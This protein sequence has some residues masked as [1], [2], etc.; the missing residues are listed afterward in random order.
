MSVRLPIVAVPFYVGHRRS[1]YNYHLIDGHYKHGESILLSAR[2]QRVIGLH[3]KAHRSESSFRLEVQFADWEESRLLAEEILDLMNRKSPP[4]SLPVWTV[5]A[6][7]F[8][9]P[10]W[11]RRFLQTRGVP[12]VHF[13][14]WF[15]RTFEL[16]G[17]RSHFA[18]LRLLGTR[19]V[20]DSCGEFLRNVALALADRFPRRGVTVAGQPLRQEAPLE[21]KRLLKTGEFKFPTHVRS[22]SCALPRIPAKHVTF[23]HNFR[24]KIDYT[25]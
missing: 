9:L 11:A 1:F 13:M 8:E 10:D 2:D 3:P 21:E 23:S 17:D 25:T 22:R 15:P 4:N 24:L 7:H 18:R 16:F 14:S 5:D 20:V 6:I 19:R 12:L